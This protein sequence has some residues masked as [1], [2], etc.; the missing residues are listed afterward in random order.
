MNTG[1]IYSDLDFYCC[2]KI[3]KLLSNNTE[4]FVREPPEHEITGKH[5]CAGFFGSLPGNKFIYSWIQYQQDNLKQFEHKELLTK[6]VVWV[7]GPRALW[8]FYEKSGFNINFGEYCD[9]LPINAYT[10]KNSKNCSSNIEPYVYNVWNE[11]TGWGGGD[12]LSKIIKII[13]KNNLLI[14]FIII[15]IIIGLFCIFK[16]KKY[17]IKH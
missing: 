12:N 3:D 2:K 13:K 5:L 14:I 9:I 7:T 11:G 6:Q 1:G 8:D 17:L 4:Y 15:I 16:F 10:N